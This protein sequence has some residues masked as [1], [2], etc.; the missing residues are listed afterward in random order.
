M[1]MLLRQSPS[2]LLVREVISLGTGF[3]FAFSVRYWLQ[4]EIFT[5][6]GLLLPPPETE[7]L[8]SQR[9]TLTLRGN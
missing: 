5:A 7:S 1:Q 8:I 6:A 2:L 3:F 9:P 4:L